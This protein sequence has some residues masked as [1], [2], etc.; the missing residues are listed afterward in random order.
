MKS[1]GRDEATRDDGSTCMND[2]STTSQARDEAQV[3]A[4]LLRRASE[5]LRAGN[6][7]GRRQIVERAFRAVAMS[8]ATLSVLLLA[9]LLGSILL[10]GIGHLN[11][12]FLSGVPS[13]I[14][15]EAGLMPAVV[16]TIFICVI[17]ACFAIPI[18]VGTAILLEEYRPYRRPWR[19]FHDFVQ[20]NITNLAGVPS[21]V[22]GLLGL[23][24]FA[25]VFGAFGTA[26]SPGFEFGIRHYDQFV[27][28][29][30]IAVVTPVDRS[31]SVPTVINP[32]T[33][34]F[35]RDT[36]KP[37]TVKVMNPQSIQTE[38]QDLDRDLEAFSTTVARIVSEEKLTGPALEE[39]VAHAWIEAG[40]QADPESM[41]S[42]LV[43]ILAEAAGQSGR[44]LRRTL[45]RALRPLERAE[46]AARLPDVLLTNAV[47]NRTSITAPWYFRIPLGRG[48]LTGGLTL[49]LVI[50]PIIIISAQESLRA[51]SGS[52]RQASLAMGASKWQTIWRVTLPGSIP[53]VMTGI[54]LA[55]S[56]AIGEAAPILII[57][58]IVYITF[59]P[60][61]LM[62]DFTAL[63][64]QVYNWASRPQSEFHDIAAAGIILL[65]ALLLV[66]NGVAVL[67]RQLSQKQH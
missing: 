60:S 5:K 19:Q 52:L 46:S 34:F 57:A 63:P 58:G 64:L 66:F 42:S 4:E 36:L 15:S 48:V 65:L 8:A 7:R 10:R 20:L 11:W 23:T 2:Q 44:E 16:G 53:G 31:D 17:A 37:M 1:A 67:I 43:P 25:N 3:D 38:M 14:A 32:A 41:K 28:A 13:R 62:D 39:A 61:H 40:L 26:K 9:W 12:N 51:V 47:P 55:M 54:I 21:L 33:R 18:G 35:N 6:R 50:L 24:A 49:M 27:T 59:A 22:Y 56:R 29:G 45:R 30:G